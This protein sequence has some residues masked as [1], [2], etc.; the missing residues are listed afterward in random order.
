MQKRKDHEKICLLEQ[1]ISEYET[2]HLEN[3]QSSEAPTENLDNLIK[4]LENELGTP[5]SPRHKNQKGKDEEYSTLITK[6]KYIEERKREKQQEAGESPDIFYQYEREKMPTKIVMGNF[7]KKT[8]IT[9]EEKHTG[10]NLD[11]KKAITNMDTQKL[12]S[13][14]EPGDNIFAAQPLLK[15]NIQNM[16]GPI[17]LAHLREPYFTRNLQFIMHNQLKDEK[18]CKMFKFAGHRI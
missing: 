4:I 16:K 7:V 15:D 2:Y 14:P 9:N 10:D 12:S 18:K 6:Q 1:A 17:P 3:K 13:A 5:S 11:R 8:Y